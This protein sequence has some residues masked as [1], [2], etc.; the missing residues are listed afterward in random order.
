M[1]WYIYQKLYWLSEAFK[2]RNVDLILKNSADIGHYIADAH[3]PLHCT[4]NYNGQFTNQSG[5]H[6]FWES[7]IPELFG[8]K[9]DYFVGR[10]QYIQDPLTDIWRVI[11]ESYIA[12]DSVLKFERILSDKFPSDKKYSIEKRNRHTVK[13][14]SYEY[15]DAYNQMLGGM[16]ERRMRA[17]ILF[18]GSIWY[19]AWVN[20]GQPDLSII[21]NKE[22]SEELNQQLKMEEKARKAKIN[23]DKGHTD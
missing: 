16:V 5:I 20:A 10:A 6:A 23:P 21:E 11:K 1:P 22:A 18:I 19:T 4:A 14:Y 8:D 3:V 13:A 2:E 7:R 12:S 17:S 15:A 9:Y